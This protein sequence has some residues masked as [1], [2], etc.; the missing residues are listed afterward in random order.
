MKKDNKKCADLVHKK[1]QRTLK[2]YQNAFNY[3]DIDKD[4]RE[5]PDLLYYVNRSGLSFEIDNNQYKGYEDFFDYVNRSGLS[6]DYVEANTFE[7]QK[8]GFWRFQMSWGGPSDEFRIYTDHEN[9]IDYIEYWYLDWFDG[10][11]IRVNDDIIYHICEMFLECS[12]EMEVATTKKQY[13][14]NKWR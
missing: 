11:F 7:D 10:A 8:S 9:N 14:F 1:Y 6:F 12:A 3:F 2:D 4:K 13:V 5:N